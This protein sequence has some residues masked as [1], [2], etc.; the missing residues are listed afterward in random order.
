MNFRSIIKSVAFASIVMGASV[1]HTQLDP[2]YR[3][4]RFN[5]MILNPAQAGANEYSDISVLGTQY[6]VGMPGAPRTGTISGN[7]SPLSN[8]GLGAAI[9]GDRT[10]PV[11]TV[12]ANVMGSYHLKLG[13]NWKLSVGLKAAALNHNVLLSELNTTQQNDPDMLNNLTTGLSFNAGYGVLLYS[14]K[15]FFGFSQPRVVG[16][17]FNRVD[18]SSFLDNNGGYIS[19]AGADLRLNDVLDFRPSVLTIFGH[20][21]PL[22]LDINAN[23]TLKKVFDFGVSYQLNG[24]LGAM[25]GVKI[26]DRLYLGYT[27]LFPLNRLN[28]VS[29]QS[30]EVALRIM[31]KK[32]ITTADSPRFFN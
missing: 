27:Y 30:H 23:F 28:T 15:F 17:R 13:Q 19:Y 10:G 5:S 14:K 21:G 6:W 2:A 18:F 29:I 12:S 25:L 3:Q 16:Y 4:Y 8:V 22:Y 26:Q 20:G 11:N 24:S 9:I 32:K 31:F 7:F 1:A